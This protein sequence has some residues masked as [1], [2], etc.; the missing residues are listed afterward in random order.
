M[1]ITVKENSIV[2]DGFRDADEFF[3]AAT[4]IL[5]L[6]NDYEDAVTSV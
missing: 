5:S 3:I 1:K 2:I 4:E 6:A